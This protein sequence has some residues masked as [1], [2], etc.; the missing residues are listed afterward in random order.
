MVENLC[1]VFANSAKLFYNVNLRDEEKNKSLQ[2]D[3]EA[4]EAWSHKWQIPFNVGKCKCLHIV[5]IN[6]CWR[7]KMSGRYLEDVKEEKNLGVVYQELKLHRQTAAAV[8]KASSSLG[9]V[10]KTFATLD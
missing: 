3:I 5:S 1:Q 7:Y 10:K 6:P 4:L 2:K 9:L 8:K